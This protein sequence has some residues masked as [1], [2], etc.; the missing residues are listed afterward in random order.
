MHASLLNRFIC[1]VVFLLPPHVERRLCSS[2]T[3]IPSFL[4][5]GFCTISRSSYGD[6]KPTEVVSPKLARLAIL[7]GIDLWF[8][9]GLQGEIDD[10]EV[11][12]IGPITDLWIGGISKLGFKK[13]MPASNTEVKLQAAISLV[14]ERM[15]F[16][17]LMLERNW[18]QAFQSEPFNESS[19]GNCKEKLAYGYYFNGNFG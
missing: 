15:T 18:L 7:G 14:I 17:D 1:N 12:F 5:Y 6:K 9:R 19:L 4:L 11:V 16:N 2:S 3:G 8:V 13:Q 10:I